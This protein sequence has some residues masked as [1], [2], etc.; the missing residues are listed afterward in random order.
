LARR[1]I[2]LG[3]I[4]NCMAEDVAAWPGC[5]FAPHFSCA[6]FSFAAGAVK[7][8]VDIYLGA[9]QC[10]DVKAE[11]ALYVGDGGDDEL[12][13]ARRAGLRVAQATWFV[14]RGLQAGV[15]VVASPQ[16][17]LSIV[18]ATTSWSPYN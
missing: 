16:D 11:D 4:S 10:L 14:A 6:V 17:V 5:A 18:T 1:G 3:T 13:G 12:S 8:D 7:P 15:P 9:L 2:R